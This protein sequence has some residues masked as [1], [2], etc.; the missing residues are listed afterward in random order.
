MIPLEELKLRIARLINLIAMTNEAISQYAGTD[1]LHVFQA[2][3]YRR[4]KSRYEKELL[5]LLVVELDIQ[6]PTVSSSLKA[7]A[8]SSSPSDTALQP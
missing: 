7:V 3:Q 1:P 2:Q 5:D 6:L 4:L 8:P